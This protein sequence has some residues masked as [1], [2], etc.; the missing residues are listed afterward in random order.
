MKLAMS[1][2]RKQYANVDKDN[3]ALKIDTDR[4][5]R[6]SVRP[7]RPTILVEEIGRWDDAEHIHNWFVRNVRGGSNEQGE[8]IVT[9]AQLCKLLDD[10]REVVK[11]SQLIPSRSFFGRGFGKNATDDITDGQLIVDTSAARKFLP[12]TTR[13]LGRKY[14]DQYMYDL[15]H[16]ISILLEALDGD[17]D[18]YY[19][20]QASW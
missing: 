13:F 12:V 19:T 3:K 5:E 14:D 2:F 20:Y 16:T 7:Y 6:I 11:R 9:R 18:A 8:V 10:A 4:G 15:H 1:L 17:P